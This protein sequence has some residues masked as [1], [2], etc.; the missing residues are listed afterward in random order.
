MD[1]M[2]QVKLIALAPLVLL[3]ACGKEAPPAIISERPV[4]V[5]VKVRDVCPSKKEYDRLSAMRPKPLREQPVPASKVEKIGKMAAQL[6]LYEADGAL[7]DQV[8]AALNS[9]QAPVKTN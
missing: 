1:G 3:A 8:F 4:T 5:E 6:G 9:C 2:D 7:V